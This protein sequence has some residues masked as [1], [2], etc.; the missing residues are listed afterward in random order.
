MK[1]H[2]R[3][4]RWRLLA[5]AA[6][7]VALGALAGCE[8]PSSST[9]QNR[10][11]PDSAQLFTVPQDQM[12]HVQLITVSPTTLQRTLRLTGAVAYNSF[13]TTPVITQVSGPVSRIAVAP[14]Q[15]VTRGQPM[16]YVASPDYSQLRTNYLKA[17]DAYQLAQKESARAQ[18]LY[19]HHALAEKDLLAAQ[20]AEVQAGAD[21]A[22]A[23]AALKVM[24]IN[25]PDS[26]I[27]GPP[28][29]EVPV[30]API[31]GEV[32]EQLV[33]VGQLI[34]PGSTQC[35][36]ISDISNVW[37]LVNVYQKDLPYVHVGEP[38]TVQT[39]AYPDT[40]RGRISYVS[41]ALDPNTRTLQARIETN[42]PGGKLKRDMY[43]VAT[44]DAGTI[45]NAI[46]VPDAAVLRDSE[47][48]PFVYAEFSP[49]QF[50]K[51]AVTVGE[52]MKGQTEINSGVK[53]GDRVISDGSLFLQFANSLQR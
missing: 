2:K 53:P 27:A 50:G 36:T 10:K 37:V 43:V 25:D 15:R 46:A 45:R 1:I 41:T 33:S 5:A 22:S 19:A 47:N 11:D 26:V 18:D 28:S 17:K 44:V 12:A 14:G 23:A 20:S 31:S 9:T 7:I 8:G 52:S 13:R 49:N 34:Q 51:R 16:L 39:D 29:F 21:M 35:F 40:F 6:A 38:V 30:L 3:E 32:V 4:S 24:G 48:L 42:N